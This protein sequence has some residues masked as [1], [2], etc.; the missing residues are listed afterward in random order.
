MTRSDTFPTRFR[1]IGGF[2]AI[3]VRAGG[4]W[5]TATRDDIVTVTGAQFDAFRTAADFV[6]VDAEGNPIKAKPKP[7]GRGRGERTETQES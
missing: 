2:D 6:Q 7:R 3:D 5:V 1:Y 4:D